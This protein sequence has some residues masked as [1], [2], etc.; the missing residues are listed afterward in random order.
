MQALGGVLHRGEERLVLVVGVGAAASVAV[1]TPHLPHSCDASAE[2]EGGSRRRGRGWGRK[3]LGGWGNGWM[4]SLRR[5]ASSHEMN[6]LLPALGF[7]MVP[8]LSSPLLLRPRWGDLLGLPPLPSVLLGRTHLLCCS[9]RAAA[10]PHSP[11]VVPVFLSILQG[12]YKHKL[13]K[14]FFHHHKRKPIINPQHLN[15]ISP[16]NSWHY[17][18][19]LPSTIYYNLGV[20]NRIQ[21]CYPIIRQAFPEL[22]LPLV[23]FTGHSSLLLSL[24]VTYKV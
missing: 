18:N 21:I 9:A 24:L 17:L 19:I 7:G 5:Q 1:G 12:K 16:P 14:H 13:H 4:W 23:L 8:L 2:L 20:V 3:W 11:R 22:L 15:L 6:E 10:G